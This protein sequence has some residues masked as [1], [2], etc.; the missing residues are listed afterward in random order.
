MTESEG[1]LLSFSRAEVVAAF[2]ERGSTADNSTAEGVA[3]VGKAVALAGTGRAFGVV[4]LL[5]RPS[6]VER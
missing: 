2:S 5:K 1:I 6:R 4:G 3:L